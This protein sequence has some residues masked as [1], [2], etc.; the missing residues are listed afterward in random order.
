VTNKSIEQRSAEALVAT[1]IQM[2]RSAETARA[3]QR[4]RQRTL[5]NRVRRTTDARELVKL[6]MRLDAQQSQAAV[7]EAAT[8]RFR[9]QAPN[10]AQ[11]SKSGLT[12]ADFERLGAR[13]V[14]EPSRLA[15]EIEKVK[16]GVSV[17][18]PDA[19]PRQISRLQASESAEPEPHPATAPTGRR[20]KPPAK[21]R[22]KGHA[23]GAAAAAT[24]PREKSKPH[25]RHAGTAHAAHPAHPAHPARKRA[26]RKRGPHKKDDE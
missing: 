5:E 22:A 25:V 23:A 1:F 21:A 10:L 11:F 26:P 16:L 20:A 2:S 19:T 4:L 3:I 8:D 17:P 18:V 24:A 9:Y 13:H 15:A 6:Q 14:I 12:M 7:L